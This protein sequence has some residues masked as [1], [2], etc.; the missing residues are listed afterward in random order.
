MGSS[1][2]D[3]LTPTPP[4]SYPA[5][6]LTP[7][8]PVTVVATTPAATVTGTPPAIPEEIPPVPAVTPPPA[9]SLV[10]IWHSWNSAQTAALDAML[11]AF[12]DFYPEIR[13]V[14]T[15]IPQTD[16]RRSYETAVYNGEGPDLLIAPA[17]WG[18]AYYDSG[19]VSNLS[20]FASHEFLSGINPAALGTGFYKDALI[21]L[22]VAQKG[23]VLYRNM[24]LIPDPAETF[25]QLMAAARGTTRAGKLG[26]YFDRGAFF[27]AGSLGGLG[28]GLM[29]AGQ[30]PIF[31]DRQG[32]AWLDLMEAYDVAGAVGMNT[33]RDLELFRTGR[34]GYIIEG[35]WQ[36]N[37]LAQAIGEENLVID[38]WP[39]FASGHLSGFVQAE[40]V[41]LSP[42]T[43]PGDMYA[44]LLFMGYLL[45][46]DVQQYLAEVGLIPA[47]IDANPRPV[48]IAQAAA[49]LADGTAYPAV[50]DSRVLTAYWEALELAIQQVFTQGIDPQE[51]LDNAEA[52]VLKRLS[53]ITP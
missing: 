25:E 53:E 7:T 48:H 5:P 41:F 31:N 34:I 39:T 4:G 43:K 20:L 46:P 12:Q 2:P 29:D 33:N 49:A 30:V 36:I 52:L 8:A 16:L 21:C 23:V 42:N 18:P 28:G 14:V 17:E 10:H 6:G 37:T 9:G 26:S 3:I 13:F 22:P 15:K 19:L 40:S 27:S 32:L 35:T 50:A 1:T 24:Q 51:A 38:P 47:A 11:D 45:T 44:A